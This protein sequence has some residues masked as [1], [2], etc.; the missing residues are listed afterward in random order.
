VAT[1][2]RQKIRT[3]GRNRDPPYRKQIDFPERGQ[4]VKR[5]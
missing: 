1:G 2:N 3:R 5:Y 4:R